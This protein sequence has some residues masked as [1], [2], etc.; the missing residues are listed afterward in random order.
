MEVHAHT[1]SPRKKW[2][3]Y[4]WEFIMLFLAVFC[5]F[6][7]ENQREH[8]IEH[9]REKLYIRSLLEDLQTDTNAMN[10]VLNLALNQKLKMDTLMVLANSDNLNDTIIRSLYEMQGV[11][12]RNFIIRFEDRT[13][14]QLKNAGGMRL[15]R[16]KKVSDSIRKYWSRIETI[17]KWGNRLESAGENISDLSALIFNNKYYIPT[18]FHLDLP[19]LRT[20]E[21]KLIDNDPKLLAQYS[22]KVNTKRSRTL[23]YI[24]GLEGSIQLA[25]HLIEMIKK[26]YHL[27]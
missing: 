20:G 12:N 26:E 3:H 7:A 17:E 6:L 9:K 15:I 11:T 14:S 22:N 13:S 18:N 4:F 21:V 1:H 25:K 27:D 16:N 2:T 23:V 19:K 5:G 8:L 24:N 10:R